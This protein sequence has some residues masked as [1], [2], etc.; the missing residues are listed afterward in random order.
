[1][2]TLRLRRL[3]AVLVARR[4]L[5]SPAQ[6]H[7]S[8]SDAS[9]LSML[10]IAVSVAAPVALLSAGAVLTVV[11]V[12]ASAVGT[13]W[14]LERASDGA[15]ASIELAGRAGNGLSVAAG[16]AVTVT[17]ISTG[18]VLRRPAR[19]SPSSPTRSAPPCSTTRGSRDE[20][21]AQRRA[22]PRSAWRWPSRWGSAE[23]GRSCEQRPLS[24][25]VGRA[26]HGAGREDGGAARP[27]RRAGRRARPR[28]A[29]PERI[30]PALLAPRL[31]LPRAASTGAW[32]VVHKLNQCG[33]AVLA[34]SPG[35]GRVLPRR[36][37]AVRGG[38]RRARACGAGARWRPTLADNARV[39]RLDTPAYNMVA[40]PW[41]GR[42]QQSNQWAIET[43]AMAQD[44][45]ADTRERA[46][47]WLRLK[48]YEPTDAAPVGAEAARRAGLL[49]QR[50]LRRP[51]QREALRRS[52]RDGDG[53]LG[54]SLARARRPR[55]TAQVIR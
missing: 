36:P 3:A 5:R 37:L 8:P 28:R 25:P 18:W 42:Y 21:L 30:R 10:P 43:L 32:R 49:R 33:S 1:M 41:S 31:R 7:S 26:R 48:G 39:A 19:R 53:R 46:Q 23:A 55:R 54:V 51:P 14:V 50:R 20:P 16:T 45:G 4:D 12:Q 29:G 11:S 2:N 17:A 9:A 44:A 34:L 6:A 13:V 15:R 24:A 52:H 47:A 40:Y 27:D 38:A 22:S 35:P